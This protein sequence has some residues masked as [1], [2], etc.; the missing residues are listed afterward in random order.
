M[1]PLCRS[2]WRHSQ[3]VLTHTLHVSP[4]CVCVC[5]YFCVS[6][7]LFAL[8]SY[9]GPGGPLKPLSHIKGVACV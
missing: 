5:V 4:V 2:I 3:C 8:K 7:S 1:C 9:L 6:A